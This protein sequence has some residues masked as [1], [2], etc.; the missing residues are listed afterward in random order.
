MKPKNTLDEKAKVLALG[1]SSFCKALEA[2]TK[3]EA[4]ADM[5]MYSTA[6]K[7]LEASAKYY[8]KT[9]FKSAADYAEATNTLS[10]AYMYMNKAETETE[11]RRK[12]QYY[13]M[14][15]KLLQASGGSYMQAKHPEKAEQVQRLLEGIREKKQLALS[16]TEVLHAPTITSTTTSFSTPTPKEQAVGLERFEQANIQANLMLCVKE[17]GVGEDVNLEIELINAGKTPALL[18]KVEKA[19]PE[20]FEFKAVPETY[21]AEDSFLDLRGKRL[22][23]LKTEEVKM[24]IQ[25][26]AKGTFTIK[27]RIRYLDENG[28]YKSHEPEPVTITVKELGIK[29]WIKGER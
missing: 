7:H 5:L 16:L 15:E 17:V 20:G 19:I 10:D 21:R 29:G 27:P 14:A 4:T 26:L 24:V 28:K 6:K 1:H 18:I 25:P 12:A 22:N 3:F 2:G 13:Q 11:P 23:P 9:G 8:L